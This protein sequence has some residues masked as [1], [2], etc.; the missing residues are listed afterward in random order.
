[1][2]EDRIDIGDA[3]AGIELLHQGVIRCQPQRLGTHGGLLARHLDDLFEHG[4]E[5]VPITLRARLAPNLHRLGAQFGMAADE[6]G[7][8][9]GHVAVDALELTERQALRLAV[10]LG[11]GGSDPVADLRRRRRLV[12]HAGKHGHGLGPLGAAALGHEDRLVG[13][14]NGFGMPECFEFAAQ[15]I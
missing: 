7:R 14:E 4:A 2:G 3:I 12:M 11:F 15:F 13:V 5:P 1:M 9:A 10:D 6:I 8:Q